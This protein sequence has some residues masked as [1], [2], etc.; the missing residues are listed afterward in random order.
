MFHIELKIDFHLFAKGIQID[1]SAWSLYVSP[2]CM[3][4]PQQNKYAV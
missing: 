2:L 1:C 3:P 4:I